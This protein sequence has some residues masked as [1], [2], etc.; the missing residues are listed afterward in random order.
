MGAGEEVSV[1]GSYTIRL[2]MFLAIMFAIVEGKTAAQARN[3][4]SVQDDLSDLYLYFDVTL[5]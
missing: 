2:V 4:V 1:N 3:T 5:H